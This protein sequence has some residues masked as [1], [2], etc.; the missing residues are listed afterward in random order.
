MSNNKIPFGM[1]DGLLVSVSEVEKGLACG[2]ICPAC[3]RKLQANKGQKVAHY[4]SHDPTDDMQDC[5]SAFETVIH[6]MAKQILEEEKS[7]IFP[8]LS[9]K[10]TKEDISGVVHKEVGIVEKQNLKEF[11]SVQLETK[12]G[13]I[14]PDI[15]AYQGYVP[16]LVE[17]AVT[18]FADKDK[19]KIIKDKSL[20]AIE[21]DL[22]NVSY[23]TTKEKRGQSRMALT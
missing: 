15:I 23:K 9:V 7:A 19:I 22:S 1:K 21:I 8:E 4:F 6:L 18:H 12:L 13:N 17:V 10:V 11:S 20:P 16:V 2:C 5:N 14:R 3:K